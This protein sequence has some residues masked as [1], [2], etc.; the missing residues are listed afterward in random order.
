MENIND[1]CHPGSSPLQS[2]CVETMALTASIFMPPL[3]SGSPKQKHLNATD[4][5]G[6][7][8]AA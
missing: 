1:Q 6:T 8:K 3:Q 2:L 4:V 7:L 5:S